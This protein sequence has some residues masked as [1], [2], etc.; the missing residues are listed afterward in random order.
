MSFKTGECHLPVAAICEV[1]DGLHSDRGPD[2]E[3]T[4]HCAD[5]VLE[6]TDI[7]TD[8]RSRRQGSSRPE[9]DCSRSCCASCRIGPPS[10]DVV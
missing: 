9:A 2:G 1:R 10:N 6:L 4:E 3:I 8:L 7:Y 5:R